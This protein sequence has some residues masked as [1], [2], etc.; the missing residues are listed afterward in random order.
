MM[1]KGLCIVPISRKKKDEGCVGDIINVSYLDLIVRYADK[2]QY[3]I[4]YLSKTKGLVYY[5]SYI[6]YES[7]KV[8]NME[9]WEAIVSEQIL[10]MCLDINVPKV[11]LMNLNKIGYKGLTDKIRRRGLT[12]EN[13][14]QGYK[15]DI[16]NVILG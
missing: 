10:R 6:D 14:I 4:M 8:I 11:V 12:V 1:Y 2:N 5:D 15:E 9:L 13:P 7:N 3:A 16:L